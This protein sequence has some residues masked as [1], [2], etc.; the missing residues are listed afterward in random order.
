MGQP[1]RPEQSPTKIG[2]YN[3]TSLVEFLKADLALAFTLLQTAALKIASDPHHARA[4]I[5]KA[6]TALRAARR[7]E[8]RIEDPAVWSEIHGMGDKLELAI[9]EA[10]K[11]T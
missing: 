7:F 9:A 6:R 2:A 8:E 4:S 11:S 5:E 3:Q 1:D 10:E